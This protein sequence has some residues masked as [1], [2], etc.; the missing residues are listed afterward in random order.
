MIAN[1]IYLFLFISQVD[2]ALDEHNQAVLAGLLSRLANGQLQ[3]AAPSGPAVAAASSSASRGGGVQVICVSH[4]AA[5]QKACDGL[6]QLSRQQT[7]DTAVVGE[8]GTEKG[9]VARQGPPAK[10]KAKKA[11]RK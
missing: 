9:Q 6:V 8:Q 3:H 2:A 4:Q 7:G 10:K 1:G 5:F 11:G